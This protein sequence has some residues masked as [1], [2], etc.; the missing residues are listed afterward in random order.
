MI[1]GK[2]RATIGYACHPG[3]PCVAKGDVVI[4]WP[5]TNM[6]P[7]RCIDY[8]VAKLDDCDNSIGCTEGEVDIL[9]DDVAG[10]F[11]GEG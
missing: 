1:I 8:F 9:C 6:P 7:D 3:P 10:H 11:D 2:M 4:V 5:A